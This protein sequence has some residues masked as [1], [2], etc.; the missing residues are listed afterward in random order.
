MK[1]GIFYQTMHLKKATRGPQTSKTKGKNQFYS[2]K[3][4]KKREKTPRTQEPPAL[5]L[6]FFPQKRGLPRMSASALE[7]RLRSK[8]SVYLGHSVSQTTPSLQ[9]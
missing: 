2:K 3:K 6:L 5:L 1:N 7:E 4:K 9:T 8:E